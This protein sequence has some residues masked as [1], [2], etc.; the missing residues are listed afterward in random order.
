M[1]ISGPVWHLRHT[2]MRLPPYRKSCCA[3]PGQ[4][5]KE[6]GAADFTMLLQAPA[7]RNVG[8]SAGQALHQCRDMAAANR[9]ARAVQQ[10]AQHSAPCEGVIQMQ[11]VDPP[12]DLQVLDRE[13][14]R[15]VIDGAPADVQSLR[16]LGHGKIVIAVDHRFALSGERAFQKIVLQRQLPDLG[17]RRLQI[18]R[19]RTGLALLLPKNAG[20]LT[21]NLG[22]PLR[23]L[24]G[25]NIELLSQLGQRLL[26]LQGGQSRFC[27]EGRGVV[28]RV[29][30]S[31]S[32]LLIRSDHA[33]RC[34]AEN[35]LMLLSKYARPALL[36]PLWTSPTRT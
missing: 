13:G 25:M 18:R 4:R 19:R 27:L 28:P 11:L 12:H 34:Q 23:E 10:I 29:S 3:L 1:T 20:R 26:A 6:P 32:R 22:F 15:L 35:P 9:N 31:S 8:G 14:P 33:R 16:L 17:V 2:A 30:A 24:I 5:A 36:N 7:A 21:E